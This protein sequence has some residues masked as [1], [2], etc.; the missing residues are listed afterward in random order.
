MRFTKAI[1]RDI[2]QAARCAD[3]ATNFSGAMML[4]ENEIICTNCDAKS[5][6]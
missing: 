4:R 1:V 6:A 3:C 2:V 5:F